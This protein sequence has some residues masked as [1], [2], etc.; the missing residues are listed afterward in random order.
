MHKE[1]SICLHPLS[2]PVWGESNPS[3]PLQRCRKQ[4][5][6]TTVPHPIIKMAKNRQKIRESSSKLN[7]PQFNGSSWGFY[8]LQ[9]LGCVTVPLETRSGLQVVKSFY[10]NKLL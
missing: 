9:Q 6:S 3:I 5:R 8:L 1:D 7:H 10:G 4:V 2:I